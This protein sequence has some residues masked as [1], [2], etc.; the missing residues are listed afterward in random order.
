MGKALELAWA[1]TIDAAKLI[2]AAR[3]AETS[4]VF[5]SIKAAS[6]LPGAKALPDA[7]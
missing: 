2:T 7:L 3:E 6:K 5:L 1:G 4:K